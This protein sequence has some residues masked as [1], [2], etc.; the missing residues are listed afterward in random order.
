MFDAA[1]ECQQSRDLK[2]KGTPMNSM[3][4]TPV[5][6]YLTNDE[7]AYFL[8]LLPRTLEKQ[9]VLGTGPRFRKFGRRV[10]Y[11]TADLV[12]WSNDHAFDN[13]AQAFE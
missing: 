5:T 8:K 3:N 12:S 11:D 4:D 9:R 1:A 2:C 7:A 13:T 10:V 6:Q